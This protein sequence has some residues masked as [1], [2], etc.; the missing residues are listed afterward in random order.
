MKRQRLCS[1][2]IIIIII[3]IIIKVKRK[4]MSVCRPSAE[5]PREW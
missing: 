4:L 1:V 5:F 2:I 3:I